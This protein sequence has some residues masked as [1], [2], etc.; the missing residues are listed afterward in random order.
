MEG[1]HSTIELRPRTREVMRH[2]A[3]GRAASRLQLPRYAAP[4]VHLSIRSTRVLT[5][6]GLQPA[7]VR[8]TD[9]VI[10]AVDLSPNAAAPAIDLGDAVLMPGVVDT[11]VHVNEPGR[12]EWEGFATAGRAAAA[13][14]VTTMVVMPLNCTPAAT[15]PGALLAEAEAAR[16]ACLIDFG[17][18]GGLVA[19]NVDQLPA[20]RAGGALGFKCFL[21]HSGVDDFPNVAAA[22]LERAAPVIASMLDA[23]GC[24]GNVPLLIHAE[25][26]A[27]LEAARARSGIEQHPSS[28]QAYLQSRPDTSETIAIIRMIELCRRTGLRTHIVHVS[29]DQALE[30]LAAARADGLPLTAETC[31][32]YLVLDAE[33]I[34]DGET[35]FKCAPPIRSRNNQ[36]RLWN[37]LL[38]GPLGMVASDHSPCPPELKRLATGDFCAAWGGISSL[39]LTLPLMW[40]EVARRGVDPA[41]LGDWLS[42]Q[43]AALAGLSERKGRI[44]PGMDA[45]LVVFDPTAEW[46]VDGPSL[47]HRHKLT[48]YHGRPVRGRILATLLRGRLIFARPEAP[49]SL[50]SRFT[51]ADDGFSPEITG[52]WLTPNQ[53]RANP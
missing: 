20:L 7:T 52:Q 24:A 48:P 39:E 32:H 45:D 31:P 8:I 44:A 46:T 3:A 33:Q 43:P 27:T 9:G 28:Y 34:A 14:G 53:R 1:W 15:T 16:A 18:W 10:V 13:G 50:T 23:H 49:S 5:P 47:H 4:I 2:A 21:V 35:A 11:H 29:S 12:T 17:L 38:H 6:V 25:D 40:T 42:A 37:G 22:D 26:E 51:L 36:T 30:P 19:G 41:K